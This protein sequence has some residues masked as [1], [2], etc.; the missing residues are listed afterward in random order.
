MHNLND[1]DHDSS[2][3]GRRAY[4]P[5]RKR[6]SGKRPQLNYPCP[7]CGVVCHGGTSFMLHVTSEHGR[8]AFDARDI[9][10]S[11]VGVA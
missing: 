8:H 9:L 5:R 4:T 10:H 2:E 11:L 6:K 3:H 7:E 1:W